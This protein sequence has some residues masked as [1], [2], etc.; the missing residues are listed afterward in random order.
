MLETILVQVFSADV[1]RVVVRRDV[2]YRNASF[3]H[4]H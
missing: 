2:F 1:G 4:R 3:R